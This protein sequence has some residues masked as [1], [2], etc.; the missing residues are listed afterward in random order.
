MV[1]LHTYVGGILVSLLLDI[2]HIEAMEGQS[3][4]VELLS[5]DEVCCSF[6]SLQ[7]DVV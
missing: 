2:H 1:Y 7:E 3:H 6:Q 5:R 4:C